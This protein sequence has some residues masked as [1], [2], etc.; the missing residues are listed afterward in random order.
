MGKSWQPLTNL[1]LC[2][3]AR[4]RSAIFAGHFDSWGL[5]LEIHGYLDS[6]IHRKSIRDTAELS[7]GLTINLVGIKNTVTCCM[8][9]SGAI[10]ADGLPEQVRLPDLAQMSAGPRYPLFVTFVLTRPIRKRLLLGK[11]P[12]ELVQ[13]GQAPRKLHDDC[14]KRLWYL[15]GKGWMRI[16]YERSLAH[17]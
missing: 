9:P 16:R 11:V 3:L 10:W 8:L 5:W 14:N 4:R 6:L 1:R 13:S 15:V 12:Q 2:Y 17:I 7:V